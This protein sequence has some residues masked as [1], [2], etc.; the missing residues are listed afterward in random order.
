MIYRYFRCPDHVSDVIS[1]RRLYF[2]NPRKFN[3]P[4]ESV[5]MFDRQRD[6]NGDTKPLDAIQYAGKPI[7]GLGICCFSRTV[8][9]YLL[10][11]HYADSHKG[12]C[13]GFDF[14]RYFTKGY[15]V[16]DAQL[17][18]YDNTAIYFTD[19][20]YEPAF[21]ELPYWDDKNSGDWSLGADEAIQVYAHKLKGW[22]YELEIRAIVVSLKD[23]FISFPPSAL[24]EIAFGATC[25]QTVREFLLQAVRSQANRIQP[26]EMQLDPKGNG[27]KRIAIPLHNRD[28]GGA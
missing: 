3:D 9:N 8:D 16:G 26:F 2:A 7:E 24:Q 13:L 27:L 4:L 25:P 14:G 18:Q 12:V 11:S 23:P 6:S 20:H 5:V 17:L 15:D 1:T 28:T 22:H 10:W 21:F 19:V